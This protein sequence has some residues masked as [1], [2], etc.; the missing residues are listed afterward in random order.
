GP[1][2][3]APP[4]EEEPP[5]TTVPTVSTVT[6]LVPIETGTTIPPDVLDPYHPLPQAPLGATVRPCR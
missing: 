5:E 4:A 1:P 2:P 3:A 6:R